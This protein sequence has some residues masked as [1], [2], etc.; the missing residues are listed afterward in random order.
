MSIR[1]KASTFL[2]VLLAA[3]MIAQTSVMALSS[4]TAFSDVPAD[5]WYA[6]HVENCAML[7]IVKGYSDGTFKPDKEL[8]RGEYMCMLAKAGDDRFIQLWPHIHGTDAMFCALLRRTGDTAG[9]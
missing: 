7:E 5:A 2:I 9:E 1:N 4:E 8:T 3:V 6:K